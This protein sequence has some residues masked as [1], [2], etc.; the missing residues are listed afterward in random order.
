MMKEVVNKNTV[1]VGHSLKK[2]LYCTCYNFNNNVVIV[3]MF[4]YYSLNFKKFNRKTLDRR[5]RD[6]LMDVIAM[7]KNV[8]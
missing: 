5:L 8:E 7:K 1:L 2:G 4:V 3:G 6:V